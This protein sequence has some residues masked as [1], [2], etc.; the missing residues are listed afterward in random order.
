MA[1]TAIDSLLFCDQYSTDDMRDIF[2]ERSTIQAWLDTEVALAEA[3]ATLGII[4]REAAE[5]IAAAGDAS[6]YDLAEMKHGIDRS[7]QAIVTL[8]RAVKDKCPEHLGEFVHWGATTQD[9]TDTGMVL[10]I[11]QAEELISMRLQKLSAAL[12]DLVLTHAATIMP[13]RTSGQHALPITFGYKAAVWLDTVRRHQD[14]LEELR[15]RLMVG[16]YGGA[17]GTLAALGD[18]GYAVRRGMMERLGLGVPAI[19][20]HTARDR[21]V[22]M[23]SVMTM[24]AGA[25]GQIA[26]EVFTLQRTEFQEL[27]EPVPPGKVGSS[28]MPHKRNPSICVQIATLARTTRANLPL[29]FETLIGDNERDRIGMQVERDFIPRTLCQVDAALAKTVYLVEG[30]DVR[31]ENMRDNLNITRGLTMSEAVMYALGERMGRQE[32][33]DV[34]HKACMVAFTHGTDM[35]TALLADASVTEILTDDEIDALLEPEAYTGLAE[36]MARDVAAD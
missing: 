1:A 2:S 30:L 22:E 4:P 15:P 20:W 9:I 7:S 33:H 26:A 25:C 23:V 6:D 32:A 13:G 21:L 11:R 31:A 5:A 28:T 17:V 19:T 35:R 36:R 24:I 3:E 18:Q 29:A 34:L 14:R 16:Q 10:Q 8:V 12:L 27:E